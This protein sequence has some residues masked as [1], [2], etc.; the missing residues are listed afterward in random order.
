MNAS[1]II[2]TMPLA[3]FLALLIFGRKLGEPAAGWLATVAAAA[4]FVAAVVT[5]FSLLGRS[6]DERSVIKS[7]FA[8]VPVAGLHVDFSL[9]LDPLSVT[10]ALFVTGVGSLIHLYSI[11][12][13]HGDERFPRFFV[14][15]NLFLF[16]MLCL[17]LAD[18]FLFSFLGW[19]GVG[20]CSYQL[21]SFWFER[22][23]P[24][25]AGKKAFVTNRVGDF[26]FMIGVFLIFDHFGSLNY[27]DVLG[28]LMHGAPGALATVTAT[29]IAL[30]LFLGAA[31]KS[32]QLPLYIWLP[33]AM[34]GPTP[35]SALIHAATM[36]TAGV[37]LMA[38]VAPILHYAPDALTV[39]A[40]VGAATA[41]Y[42]A[43]IACAQDDIKKVLA[44][45]TISQLGYMFL[46]I[47]AGAYSAGL[48]HMITH[49]FF[50]ALLFLG[51]G[52]VIHGLHEQQDMKKMGGL[53]K[54]MPITFS[55][56]I[57]GWLA[58]SG[59]FPFSGFWSKDDILAAAW[60]SHG[61]L[62][63]VLWAVGF[64]TAGLT[65]YYMS[66]QVAL[67]FLGEA[68]WKDTR[69]PAEAEEGAGLQG[70]PEL[71][72]HEP[73]AQSSGD[74][75]QVEGA[76]AGAQPAGGTAGAPG[77]SAGAQPA[78][79]S[80]GGGGATPAMVGASASTHAAVG[81]ATADH[82]EH[83]G[84]DAHSG[85]PHEAPWPMA[86]PLLVLGA[87]AAIG[88]VINLP[89]GKWDLLSRWLEP[90]F[91]AAI[92]PE[93]HVATAV[94]LTLALL[95][96]ALCLGGLALGLLPW[97]R[98]IYHPELEPGLLK[99]AWYFDHAIS[100]FVGGPGEE[101]AEFAAYKVDK[102]VIDGAV[103]GI[104]GL[105]A[106]GG[107]WLRKLQT[108]Y[109]RNYALGLAGGAALLLLYVTVRGGG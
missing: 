60:G 99:N 86:F 96:L 33:D 109:V 104:A 23:R 61:Q 35:V 28:P 81:T 19:E 16:S 94:K 73:V 82:G 15:L 11:G 79:G 93:P 26:G 1:Y 14:L 13:M 53:K 76:H 72:Q 84:H 71:T 69:H 48:F 40:I 106:L 87:L 66:R 62:G 36:V 58:I 39:I 44:Y 9:Q 97:L 59:I 8:W 45:S 2:L 22:E 25:A 6:A 102:G 7:I 65:A 101:L 4:S 64:L 51:A 38:R 31:G 50:K 95:T 70:K 41:L 49:A 103:N 91:P 89:W 77:G 32:A 12:Y 67:V 68:R 18:N 80:G 57:I 27:R 88:G 108:G 63:K 17:V 34:E 42:A 52:S 5:F 98:S 46:G 10:M 78:G 29:G 54:W 43:T 30:M 85:D 20:F 105:T 75:T 47:G 107:R 100:A 74:A 92:A 21:I 37:Y 90:V 24:P 55:T 3:G 56:F 83:A